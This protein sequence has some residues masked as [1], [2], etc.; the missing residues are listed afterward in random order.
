MNKTKELAIIFLSAFVMILLI[1]IPGTIAEQ[2]FFIFAG[3][4]SFQFIPFYYHLTET[5]HS[6]AWGWDWIT[7]LGSDFIGSYSYYSLGS[8]FFWIVGWINSGRVVMYLTP[9]ILAL[10]F[11]V[12]SV[13]SYVYIRR[14][15]HDKKTAFIGCIMYAFSGF[16][17]VS[18]VCF[19]FSEAIALF[20]LL[21]L[22]FDQL[23]EKNRKI[24]FL[25]MVAVMAL[26][27]FYFFYCQAIFIFI[28]YIFKCVKNIYS[29]SWKTFFIIF[30][31]TCT[32]VLISS[33]L[34]FPSIVSTFSGG[35]STFFLSGTDLISYRDNTIIPSLIQS[36][37]MF[38]DP[39]GRY[40][41]F[42]PKDNQ[43]SS[44][45][46]YLP[47]FALTGVFEFIR[48]NKYYWITSFL[49]ICVV[50]AFVP[51]L[52]S[53]FSLFND[54][55]YARWLFMP[56]LFMCIATCKSIE[57]RSDFKFG[58][59]IHFSGV[60]LFLLISFLPDKTAASSTY[61]DIISGS[62]EEEI[63]WF[64]MDKLPSVFIPFIVF[65]LA[66]AFIIYYTFTLKKFSLKKF[67]VYFIFFT[68]L[69]SSFYLE[70]CRQQIVVDNLNYRE[71]MVDYT[72]ELEGDFFFRIND[73][74][75]SLI[76]NYFVWGYPSISSF[77]SLSIEADEIFYSNVATESR[78]MRSIYTENDYPV[79]GLLSVKY[80]F[81]HS[82]GD[83]LN[84]ENYGV[85][86]PG[87]SLYDKQSYYYIYKNDHFVPMGFMYDYCITDKRLRDY[88][89]DLNL[90]QSYQMNMM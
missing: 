8:V 27:N 74:N 45:S 38:P 48:R 46:L 21:L 64:A 29:F 6:G 19:Q 25:I 83:D 65:S 84:V 81:N 24:F 47:F 54:F 43:W 49:C 63:R 57:D 34:L 70:K 33:V 62:S 30:F 71:T 72:P 68:V 78:S 42:G 18:V 36:A 41:L 15:V 88:I 5:I 44:A 60:I 61:S 51:V 67:T 55:Y 26:D 17:L 1:I 56:A 69:S 80:I 52:N 89:I 9:F 86:I 73:V 13:T 75:N 12:A 14:Y 76:N 66:S 59:K 3:D 2:G 79:Y 23:L 50:I 58:L 4:Y 77:H 82:T 32:G 7:N 10:K 90:T 40:T 22:S 87:F 28:Y 37:F 85:N 11:G 39:C 35:R 16:Q 31:E 20:P 53:A